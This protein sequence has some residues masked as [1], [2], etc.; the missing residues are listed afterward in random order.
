LLKRLR[1]AVV[2]MFPLWL[3]TLGQFVLSD[4]VRI[5][6]PFT[7]I[8]IILAGYL[9]PLIIGLL[10]Q[11]Y[12]KRL[13]AVIVRLLHPMF[14]ISILLLSVVGL[15]SNFYVF[16]LIR[17]LLLL[18]GCLLPY[19]GFSISGVVAFILRQ[20]PPRIFTIAIETGFQ[21]TLLAIILMKLSLP[22]PDADMSIVGPVAIS[23][24]SVL[25]LWIAYAI[26]EIRRRFNLLDIFCINY[27]HEVRAYR[28]NINPKHAVYL[29]W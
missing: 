15:W 29:V 12:C 6:I 26:V 20:P 19:V 3:F 9:V 25:P 18:A 13:S 28:E 2:G 4:D 1:Y 21:N 24:A 27:S 10:I 16:L 7:S 14:I 23:T 11:R 22:Q 5:T 17:P 8:M